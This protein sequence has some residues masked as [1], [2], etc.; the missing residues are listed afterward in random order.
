MK[1]RELVQWLQAFPD[2]EAEVQVIQHSR[3]EGWEF[4][5]TH[6]ADFDP[7]RHAHYV[8]FRGNQFMRPTYPHYDSSTLL[9]G[10]F[11]V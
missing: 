3:G 1:V 10:E 11:D 2:Q 5:K 9:L 7:A 6:V 8:D 4:D